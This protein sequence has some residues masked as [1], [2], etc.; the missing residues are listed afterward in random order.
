MTK[1]LKKDKNQ[2]GQR[3]RQLVSRLKSTD[4]WTN[5]NSKN[6][7]RHLLMTRT[8]DCFDSMQHLY[9]ETLSRLTLNKWTHRWLRTQKKSPKLCRQMAPMDFFLSATHANL[10]TRTLHFLQTF[11]SRTTRQRSSIKALCIS[12]KMSLLKM[13]LRLRFLHYNLTV[14]VKRHLGSLSSNCTNIQTKKSKNT[15]CCKSTGSSFTE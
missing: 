7:S 5:S 9:Q 6:K 8:L 11:F 4:S 15:N 12:R 2:W 13:N 1:R 3:P 14:S 10:T